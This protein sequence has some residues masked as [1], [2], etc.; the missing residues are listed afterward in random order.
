MHQTTSCISTVRS[1]TKDYLNSPYGHYSILALVSVDVTAIFAELV[2]DVLICEGRVPYKNGTIAQD[3]LGILN[4]VFSCLF[5]VE[6]VASV[7]AFGWTYFRTFFHILDATVIITAFILD[8]LLKG[9]VDDI[10]SLV[11]VLRL[12]RVVKIISEMS[13]ATQERL[14]PRE[15]RAEELENDNEK[16]RGEVDIL[17]RMLEQAEST[18]TQ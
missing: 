18:S 6:L 5:L 7:W 1:E 13:A 14:E 17:T 2:L 16:L 12:W 8:V 11:M 10:S 3:I 15:E 9:I 4:M